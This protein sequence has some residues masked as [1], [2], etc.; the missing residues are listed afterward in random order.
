MAIDLKYFFFAKDLNDSVMSISM[1]DLHCS[2]GDHGIG[3]LWL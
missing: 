2:S 3:L 1:S